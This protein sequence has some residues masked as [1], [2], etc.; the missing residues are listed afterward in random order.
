MA[1]KKVKSIC[2]VLLEK[3]SKQHFQKFASKETMTII[4]FEI[5]SNPFLHWRERSNL[6]RNETMG[7]LLRNKNWC[8]N[9]ILITQILFKILQGEFPQN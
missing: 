6:V 5:Q 4:N 3:A 9:L 7:Q 8:N 2:N 1:Y